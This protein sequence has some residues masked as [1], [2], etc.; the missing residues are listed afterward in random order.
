[1]IL[2]LIAMFGPG[3]PGQ[4]PPA[5]ISFLPMVAIM[6]IFYLLLIRPQQVKQKEQRKR[7]ASLE[8]GDQ[9]ITSGGLHGQVVGLRERTVVIKVAEGVRL[10]VS[11]SAVS[12]VEKAGSKDRSDR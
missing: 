8:K 11:R 9:V 2:D 1:M 6:V 5:Y 7:I 3:E 4:K 12:E 10:E